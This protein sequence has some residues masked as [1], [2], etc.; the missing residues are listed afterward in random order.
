M[1]SCSQPGYKILIVNVEESAP[2]AVESLKTEN[3]EYV[4]RLFDFMMWNII[5]F[6]FK[7][8]VTEDQARDF[9][10]ITLRLRIVSCF[11]EGFL[12]LPAK[13]CD[14][15]PDQTADAIGM[16]ER[17]GTIDEVG[18]IGW[19]GGTLARLVLQAKGFLTLHDPKDYPGGDRYL[20]VD[21]LTTKESIKLAMNRQMEL[22]I[23]ENAATAKKHNELAT[24]YD[25]ITE[26]CNEC[27][28][29]LGRVKELYNDMK[30]QSQDT[31][32]MTLMVIQSGLIERQSW[33][34]ALKETQERAAEL[35][36]RNAAQEA[37]RTEDRKRHAE[38]RKR[39]AE[40]RKRHAQLIE[41]I[42]NPHAQQP[43]GE[44]GP[45]E[46]GKRRREY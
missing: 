27:S 35:E 8:N 39:H 19:K 46:L 24:A 26:K 3:I 18:T 13:L 34:A 33:Q 36:A 31:N 5:M 20:P 1:A 4:F 32:T 22:Q 2:I 28:S 42:K 43:T 9:V 44:G 40:E 45:A 11:N 15:N 23:Y 38:D 6:E 12:L 10:T 37:C 25:M 29:E 7:E 21:N 30:K 16:L 41:L 17:N 14:M